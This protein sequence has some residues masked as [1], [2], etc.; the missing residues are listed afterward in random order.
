MDLIIYC[1]IIALVG[2][3]RI[4]QT[5]QV[6]DDE[7]IVDTGVTTISPAYEELPIGQNLALKK[8]VGAYTLILEELGLI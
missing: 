3:M 2:F 4:G 5:A 8:E 1:V 7:G 6:S